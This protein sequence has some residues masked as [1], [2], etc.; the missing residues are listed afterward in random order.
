[1][2]KSPQMLLNTTAAAV[3]QVPSE[4]SVSEGEALPYIP[5]LLLAM[6]TFLWPVVSVLV[7]RAN[8]SG[9]QLLI[10]V[11]SFGCIPVSKWQG[12]VR[13]RHILPQL[14][15]HYSSL[16]PR[17]F[18]GRGLVPILVQ[19]LRDQHNA[20]AHDL[21]PHQLSWKWIPWPEQFTW[22][23]N[24]THLQPGDFVS[25][26]GGCTGQHLRLSRALQLRLSP[27]HAS[28][29]DSSRVPKWACRMS[30]VSF[31]VQ[32]RC[33]LRGFSPENFHGL[34]AALCP[35]LWHT[36]CQAPPLPSEEQLQL[37]QPFRRGKLSPQRWFPVHRLVALTAQ[38]WK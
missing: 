3:P 38:R 28:C 11:F 27:A 19:V 4:L 1:M 25:R 10:T 6:G 2:K 36:L 21:H 33:L 30:K 34:S 26:S 20:N 12:M 37:S 35:P 14:P 24:A 5:L 16:F 31:P 17:A 15:L 9:S 13:T 23:R 18:S 22:L 32:E 7:F 8:T 29:P